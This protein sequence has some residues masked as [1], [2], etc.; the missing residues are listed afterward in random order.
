MRHD[1][2]RSFVPLQQYRSKVDLAAEAPA[3]KTAS[4][5]SR[6]AKLSSTKSM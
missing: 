3:G 1:Q 5:V 4:R 6:E 2:H